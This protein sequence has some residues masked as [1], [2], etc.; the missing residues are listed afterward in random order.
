MIKG[1]A[2]EGTGQRQR[3]SRSGDGGWPLTSQESLSF[4][5]PVSSTF[6]LCSFPVCFTPVLHCAPLRASRGGASDSQAED[7]RCGGV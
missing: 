2:R 3:A 7:K 4:A 1:I 5:L 6:A